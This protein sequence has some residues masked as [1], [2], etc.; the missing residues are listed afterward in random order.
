M[1]KKIYS[2]GEV[3]ARLSVSVQTVRRYERL[4]KF[5]CP[6]RNRVNNRREYTERDIMTMLKVLGRLSH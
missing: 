4:G 1:T 2:V 5:P 6:H 3:A